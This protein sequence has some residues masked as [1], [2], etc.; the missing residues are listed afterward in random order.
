MHGSRSELPAVGSQAGPG[1]K[2]DFCKMG[3]VILPTCKSCFETELKDVS[4]WCRSKHSINISNFF[5]SN[6][7]VS[8]V[9]MVMF[10]DC[11]EDCIREYMQNS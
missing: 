9:S 3:I 5:F 6:Y 11:R 4:A 7:H 10:Q 1:K 2:Q 8:I